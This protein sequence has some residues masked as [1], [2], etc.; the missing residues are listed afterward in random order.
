MTQRALSN[1]GLNSD[2]ETVHQIIWR[3]DVCL[4]IFL[5]SHNKTS[6][7]GSLSF[8]ENVN[9]TFALSPFFSLFHCLAINWWLIPSFPF[10]HHVTSLSPLG[11]SKTEFGVTS[12]WF[13]I[14]FLGDTSTERWCTSTPLGGLLITSNACAQ[15]PF[16]PIWT[17]FLPQWRLVTNNWHPSCWSFAHHFWEVNLHECCFMFSNH[18]PQG[19]ARPWNKRLGV[20]VKS[21][22]LTRFPQFRVVSSYQ[23]SREPSGLLSQVVGNPILIRSD[24]T[25]WYST[26]ISSEAVT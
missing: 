5:T 25:H 12:T 4:F 17:Q 26:S 11:K 7:M 21:C 18:G 3:K 23:S 13:L 9:A 1:P 22:K 20:T 15:A 16:G 8:P 24:T 10:F 2:S 6:A 19:N 14:A